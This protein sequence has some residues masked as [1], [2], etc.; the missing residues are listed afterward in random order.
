MDVVAVADSETAAVICSKYPGTLAWKL[1]FESVLI[2]IVVTLVWFDQS[3]NR[4]RTRQAL[5]LFVADHVSAFLGCLVLPPP[6]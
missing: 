2:L 3:I 6:R 5:V 4:I 1:L